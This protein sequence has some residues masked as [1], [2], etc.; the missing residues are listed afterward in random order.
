[1]KTLEQRPGCR[2]R[3]PR[4]DLLGLEGRQGSGLGSGEGER[5]QFGDRPL[6]F[7]PSHLLLGSLGLAVGP[8]FFLGF[9]I[10]PVW[11]VGVGVGQSELRQPHTPT[12]QTMG[13]VGG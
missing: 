10:S 3:G 7:R 4:A 11:G 13:W 8:L 6:P 1:M 12:A 2:P 9:R 5:W